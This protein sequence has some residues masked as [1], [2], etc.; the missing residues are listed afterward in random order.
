ME[1]WL[2]L[3]GALIHDDFSINWRDPDT[4]RMNDSLFPAERCRL[5]TR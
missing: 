3:A 5:F 1:R 4:G 2:T